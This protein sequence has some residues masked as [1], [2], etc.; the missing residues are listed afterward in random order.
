MHDRYAQE[1]S[2]SIGQGLHYLKGFYV[3]VSWWRRGA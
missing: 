1:V 2:C 3:Q